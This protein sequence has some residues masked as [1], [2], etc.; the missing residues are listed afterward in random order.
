MLGVEKL[1][2]AHEQ[3]SRP[4]AGPTFDRGLL[5]RLASEK[6][7]HFGASTK[8]EFVRDDPVYTSLLGD[9]CEFIA[10]EAEFTWQFI[11]PTPGQR[12][13]TRGDNMVRLLRSLRVAM[14]GGTLV[15]HHRI[16]KWFAALRQPQARRALQD[17]VSAVVYRYMNCAFSWDVVNEALNPAD[18]RSDGLRR[19]PLLRIL[20]PQ[21]VNEAFVAA[22]T[23]DPAPLRVYNEYGFEYESPRGLSKRRA[24]LGLLERLLKSDVPVQALGIQSH[25][26]AA[27][28]RFDDLA[29]RAFLRDV[30][31]MGL[32][33]LVTELD[34]RDR[35]LPADMERRDQIVADVYERYLDV[36]LDDAA[37]IAVNT[38]GL[39]DHA[40]WLQ[41]AAPRRDQLPVRTLP[42]ARDL[43][44]KKAWFAIA[45]AFRHA[46]IRRALP[47]MNV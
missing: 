31:G 32:K 29:F 21:F 19:S 18:G 14:R 20:G 7:I 43:K 47:I 37:V 33:L 46:P 38:W 10:P 17:Q 16:P 40:S 25:L 35:D 11:S 15:W 28:T 34:V 3:A 41:Q 44:P 12:I 8:T 13:W 26:D 36:V 4:R 5:H 24:L 6:G 23:S 9:C 42:L 39:A 30:S 27:E 22:A 2:P 45:N 1:Q